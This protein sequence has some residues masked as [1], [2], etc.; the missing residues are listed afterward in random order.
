M[1]VKTA[2]HGALSAAISL[3][4]IR[5]AFFWERPKE[6]FDYLPITLSFQSLDFIRG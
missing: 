6:Y 3:H 1:A 4:E 2:I 5:R